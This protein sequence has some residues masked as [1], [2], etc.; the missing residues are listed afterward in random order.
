M[1]STAAAAARRATRRRTR[2]SASSRTSPRSPRR[3]RREAGGPVDVFGHSYGGRC[4]LG[5]ALLT[6]DIRRVVWYEGAPTPPGERYQRGRGLGRASSRRSRTPAT[7]TRL[8]ATFMRRVV[9]MPAADLAAYPRRPGLAAPRRPRPRRSSASSPP[10]PAPAGVARGAGRGPPAGPP[11]ARRRAAGRSVPRPRAL[12]ARLRGRPRRRR[13]RAPGTPPTTP[14]RD[15]VRRRGRRPSSRAATWDTPAMDLASAGSS[16][17]SSP[18]PSRARSSAAGRPA[19]ASRT[20]SSASSAASSAAGSPADGL[21]A[22][23]NGFIAAVVVAVLGSLVV[24]L[25][26]NALETRTEPSTRRDC[27]R[28]RPGYHQAMTD[29][30]PDDAPS[31]SRAGEPALLA[32]ASRASSPAR[33]PLATSTARNGRLLYRGYRIG[34]LVE[35]GTYPAVANLLWTGDWDPTAPPADGAG[36]RRRPRRSSAPCP[37]RPSRWTRCARRSRPGARRRTLPWPPTVEQARALTAFSP[38]ALAA[39][40]RLRAGKE[41]IEPDPSLD[42]VAGFLYQ[43]TGERAGRRRRPGRSM[44]TSSSAPSTASTPRRSRPGSSP[45]PARTSPRRSPARS[46]R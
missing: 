39:F 28:R 40:A 34:D 15:A 17:A 10:R 27:A 31:P 14:T 9:G 38:S 6:D 18:A 26:L 7:A 45:R 35:H 8:L 21:R 42:L 5:A 30:P 1:P 22:Q 43:L 23:V 41:P 32:R 29:S 25:I 4:A 46:G 11:A 44:P 24:R 20:S 13:S 19:A 16:S 12:D 36:P 3:S 33:R 2:S 37:R